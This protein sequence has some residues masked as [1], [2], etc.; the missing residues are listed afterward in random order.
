MQITAICNSTLKIIIVRDIGNRTLHVSRDNVV[1]RP[2]SVGEYIL[3][4]DNYG[5]S[6]TLNCFKIISVI[7]FK[8]DG[9][10]ML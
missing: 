5:R 2:A 1:S 8:H 6:T 7:E 3:T 4:Q 9:T 10:W